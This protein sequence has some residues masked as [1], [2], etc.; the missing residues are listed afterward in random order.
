MEGT[1]SGRIPRRL[2]AI[3]IALLILTPVALKAA[4][5]SG[6]FGRSGVNQQNWLTRTTPA[7]TSSPEWTPIDNLSY[8][9]VCL[10]KGLVATVSM[11]VSGAHNGGELRID[12]DNECC[13]SPETIT[14]DSGETASDRDSFSFTFV[15][16]L[17]AGGSRIDVEWRSP[18]GE[19]ITL[20]SGVL[21]L[22]YKKPPPKW[23]CG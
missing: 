17:S 4:D 16:A 3:A 22:L 5:Q 23:V 12:H 9:G 20:H 10:Y 18:T 21:H 19:E 13:F 8:Q 7:Y 15:K 2:G 11:D 14:F 6:E 1:R